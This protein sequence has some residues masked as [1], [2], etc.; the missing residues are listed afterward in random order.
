[1]SLGDL[2]SIYS[3]YFLV[4]IHQLT[5]LFQTASFTTVSLEL[6]VLSSQ[7]S[8]SEQTLSEPYFPFS[9]LLFSFQDAGDTVSPHPWW[10]LPSANLSI[11]VLRDIPERMRDT[12]ASNTSTSESD[13]TMPCDVLSGAIIPRSISAFTYFLTVR[14]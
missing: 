10:L 2:N 7:T 5:F 14:T 12:K 3:I 4:S 8:T 11:A 1:M 6:A 9:V 13:N